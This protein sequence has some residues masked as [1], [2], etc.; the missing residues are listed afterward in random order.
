MAMR[1]AVTVGVLATDARPF[2]REVDQVQL[3]QGPTLD[4]YDGS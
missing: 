1:V 3:G 2:G 4:V